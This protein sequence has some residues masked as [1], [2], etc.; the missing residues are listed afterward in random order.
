MRQNRNRIDNLGL[1]TEV[2]DPDRLVRDPLVSVV[3]ITYN[4]APYIAQAIEGVVSQ[5]VDFPIELIIGEDCSTD[6]TREIALDFQRRYPEMIRVLC[7]E[8]NVGM[9]KNF[10][11]TTLAA[12]GKY[13]AFC[14]GDDWWHRKDK[15][16][17]QIA[18]LDED[19]SRVCV[20]GAVR[21]ISPQGQALEPE[22]ASRNDLPPIRV[23]YADI[24]L[25]A[26]PHY[27]CTV[28]VRADAVRQVMLGDSLCRDH[29][30]M[31]GDQ[32]L[33]I[34][35]SQQGQ[36]V[37]LPETMAS[38]RHT[39]NS[40]MRQSDPLRV[41]AFE[42]SLIDIN[43]QALE[44]YPL[45]GDPDKTYAFKVLFARQILRKAAWNG[46]KIAA[47]RQWG[48]LRALEAKL[49]WGDV[50]GMAL[51][52]VPLPR[53][54]LTLAYRKITP[55]LGRMGFN[56]REYLEVKAPLPRSRSGG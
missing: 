13:I 46:D 22:K 56:L 42:M 25:H 44:R 32:P 8:K 4:H 38:Y 5:E 49:G 19:K 45:P 9:L 41:R 31:L 26:I 35:L 53:R 2:A 17:R 30:Q 3:M 47:K 52:F 18:L 11:R 48:R 27:T 34:E 40:A 1:H 28:M 37:Y 29:S 43:Y 50:A 16:R 6:R 54:S 39:P 55:L 24:L 14:E 7:S 21:H 20:A 36:M 12:R 15:L 10:H 23:E 33:W 51:A